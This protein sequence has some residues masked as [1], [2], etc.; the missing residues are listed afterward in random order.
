MRSEAD[1]QEHYEIEKRLAARLRHSSR[2]ERKPLYFAV[3]TELVE[4]ARHVLPPATSE[5]TAELAQIERYLRPDTVFLEVGAGDCSLS[6][7]VARRVRH[8]YAIE[9]SAAIVADLRPPPNLDILITNGLEI[10]VPAA[11]VT[12][13]YSNQVLEHLHADDVVDHL[14]DVL[15]GLAAPGGTSAS[16]RIA[17]PA[18]Q[19]SRS[20]ST[21]FRRDSTC[22]ITP[23]PKSDRS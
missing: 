12:L 5:R 17:S 10:P 2:E 8:V 20:T 15:A 1:I 4:S 11:S 21:R 13:A 16:R 18:R 3:Y 23:R 19:T 7:M 6:L 14:R 22:V 9:I